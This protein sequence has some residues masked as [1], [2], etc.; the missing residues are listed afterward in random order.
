VGEHVVEAT[1]VA[2]RLTAVVAQV[3]TW[4]EFPGLW[5]RLLEEVYAVVRLRSELATGTQPGERWQ[6]VM[7]YLDDA[8]SVEVGVLVA[9][10]VAPEGRVVGSRLPGGQV[11]MT[12]HRGDY[13]QLGHAHAA[14]DR[15]ATERGVALA[16]PRWE[17]YGHAR[18]DPREAQTEVC[19]LIAR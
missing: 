8:P 12:V 1:T 7:L 10:A 18:D 14:V 3:T 6:N 13:A 17:V 19:W 5:P 9:G 2:P 15:F 11:L 16:G 4:E